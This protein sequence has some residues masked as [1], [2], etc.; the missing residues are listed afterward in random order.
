MSA[1][2]LEHA[3]EAPH[4][5]HSPEEEIAHAKQHAKENIYFFATF[6]AMMVG[7]VIIHECTSFSNFWA[8]TLFAFFRCALIAV[9]FVWLV[10]HFKLISR[11]LCFTVFFLI[12]MIFLSI[13][14][15]DLPTKWANPIALS[16][17]AKTV[18]TIRPDP[19]VLHAPA[20]EK[21]KQ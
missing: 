5:A 16:E 15:S 7:A 9:F 4:A 21:E 14:D 13:F 19:M 17:K 10:G 12:G 8:F 18:N 6:F 2:H 11:T 20:V 3:E 1:D